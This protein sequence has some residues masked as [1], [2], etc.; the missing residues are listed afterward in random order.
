MVTY[1]MTSLRPMALCKSGT[2]L[3]ARFKNADGEFWKR[4][5]LCINFY[6][7]DVIPRPH[8][9]TNAQ[10]RRRNETIDPLDIMDCSTGAVE[11]LKP[12]TAAK[13]GP[14]PSRSLQFDKR[15]VKNLPVSK[16]GHSVNAL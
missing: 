16:D 13:I 12:A 4:S 8:V 10:F 6:P 3:F 11:R 1:N 15:I 2:F 7:H 5:V 9:S 14:G